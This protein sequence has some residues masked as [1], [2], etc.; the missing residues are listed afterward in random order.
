MTRTSK[1]RWGTLRTLQG[2]LAL[3]C[4]GGSL[5]ELLVSLAIG[6]VVL[7]GAFEALVNGQQRFARQQDRI[8]QQQELRIGLDVLGSELRMMGHSTR[9]GSGLLAISEQEVAFVSNV[10]GYVTTLTQPA[11]PFLQTLSVNDGSDW[12]RGKTI[13]VCSV[14]RCAIGL[15]AGDGHRKT[16]GLTQPLGQSF[17]AG[18][19][20]FVSNR[21]RYYLGRDAEGVGRIMREIDGGTATLVG[22]VAQL[23]FAYLGKDGRP[24]SAPDRVARVRVRVRTEGESRE[25]IQEIGLRV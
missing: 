9:P 17:P 5:T 20:V 1:E 13:W 25:L 11:G 6:A 21:V 3:D 14:G 18:S 16:L 12:P 10:S 2:G 4:A 7:S 23:Q 15:L 24:V 22:H 8:A 19:V